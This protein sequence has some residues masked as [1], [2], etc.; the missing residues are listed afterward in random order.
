[1][2]G[3]GSGQWYRYDSHETAEG[4]RRLDVRDWQ[5]RR[6]LRPRTT[7]SWCWYRDAAHTQEVAR[8]GVRV[9]AERLILDYRTR[10]AGEEW[11]DVTESIPL[12]RTPCTYGG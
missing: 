2:G 9:E 10:R 7:F 11:Q 6:L 8:I 12:V 3:N 1:M 5:R 4:Y